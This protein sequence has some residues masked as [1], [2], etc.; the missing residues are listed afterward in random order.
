VL[1]AADLLIDALRSHWGLLGV[2][3]LSWHRTVASRVVAHVAGAA[4]E[5]AVKIDAEPHP[6]V[7]G[8]A[9]VQAHVAELRPDLAPRPVRSTTGGSAVV[10]EGHRVTVMQWVRGVV[11]SDDPNTW[12]RMGTALAALHALPTSQRP[13]AVPVGAACDELLGLKGW[14]SSL[15]EEVATRARRLPAQPTG[16]IHGQP[17]LANVVQRDDG[18][19]A[20]LD[21]DESGT[22]PTVLDLGYPLVCHFLA[23]DFR[24]RTDEARS[25]YGG[26]RCDATGPL[27]PARKV[28]DAALF[29]ALRSAMFADH[30]HRL[31]RVRYALSHED[32]LVAAVGW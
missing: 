25:F 18:T 10:V 21:W 9:D 5:F 32:D 11:P 6:S 2:H 17:T 23:N 24:I 29:H 27:P 12:R 31:H 16:L 7:I 3:V 13:F 26:Y 28:F 15:V 20:V 30:Q 4:G 1:G 22:G 14:P 8:G 19:I